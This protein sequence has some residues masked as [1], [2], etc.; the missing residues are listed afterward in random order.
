MTVDN[1]DEAATQL[2]CIVDTNVLLADLGLLDN[3]RRKLDSSM[4]MVVPHIVLAELDGMKV[5][6]F[7]LLFTSSSPIHHKFSL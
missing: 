7:S 2:V 1:E 5:S 6:F 4:I 3:I